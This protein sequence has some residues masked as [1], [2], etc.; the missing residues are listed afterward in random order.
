MMSR[1]KIGTLMSAGAIAIAHDFA[2]I[3]LSLSL[4]NSSKS[5]RPRKVTGIAKA[6]RAAK[7]RRNKK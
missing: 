6:K 3:E 2:E 5:P 7:K 4:L 1:I